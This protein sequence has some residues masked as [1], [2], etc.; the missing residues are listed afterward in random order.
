MGCGGLLWRRRLAQWCGLATGTPVA[1]PPLLLAY[2]ALLQCRALLLVPVRPASPSR[3]DLIISNEVCDAHLRDCAPEPPGVPWRA[4]MRRRI[5][6]LDWLMF[7]AASLRWRPSRAGTARRRA[8]KRRQGW[9]AV[10]AGAEPAAGPVRF[11][12]ADSP[13]GGVRLTVHCGGDRRVRARPALACV[14]ATR[15]PP[16][17][18]P[19]HTHIH[20]RPPDPHAHTH[21]PDS[22]ARA[23]VGAGRART[24]AHRRTA[25]R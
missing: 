18:I 3:R 14:R 20:T 6:L 8:A 22:A 23:R 9:P 13:L 21:V 25:W 12:P 17:P 24:G 4:T 10:R 5:R 19:A 7:A 1:R 15:H 2:F 11:P 16:S